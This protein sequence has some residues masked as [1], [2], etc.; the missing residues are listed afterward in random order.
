MTKIVALDA[1]HGLNTP[2]KRTPDGERE[3]SFNNQ[4]LLAAKKRLEEY[5]DVKIVRLDDPTGKTDVPLITRTNKANAAKADVL[6]SIHHNANTGQWGTWTGTETFTYTPASSNP[7]S[8]ALAKA[9]HPRLVKAM[10]LRD[11]GLKAENFHMVRESNMPAILTEGGYMDSKT[12]IKTLRSDSK[13]KAAGEAIADGVAAY[14]GLKLKKVEPPKPTPK[15]SKPAE[16]PGK[17]DHIHRVIVDGKQIGAYG[18]AENVADEVKKAVA[19][20]AKK[21]EVNRV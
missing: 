21:I 19:E 15:P 1:G 16:V 11:R 3:W 2:G 7:K 6:I 20:G 18:K 10:G 12:D 8:V 5:E 9:V 14:L 13:L 17:D 4:V